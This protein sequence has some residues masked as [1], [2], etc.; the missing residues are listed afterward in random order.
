VRQVALCV[1]AAA[2]CAESVDVEPVGDY[3]TWKRVDVRGDA[4]G[5]TNS[6]RVIYANDLA[7]DPL[8]PFLFGYQEG[9]IFVKEVRDDDGGQPG[10]L[11][12]RAYMRRIGTVTRVLENEGGWLYT[13]TDG[14]D[15]PEQYFEFCW[16]RCHVVAPYNGAFYDYRD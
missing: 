14:A 16:N 11:R 9:A 3:S 1:V 2:A 13:E 6:Y 7:V 15:G 10:A 8:Q 12:Y 4:P 5:H